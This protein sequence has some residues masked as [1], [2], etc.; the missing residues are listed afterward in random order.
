M[1]KKI[2]DIWIAKHQKCYEGFA[3]HQVMLK[4]DNRVAY[5][6]FGDTS[7]VTGLVPETKP[8][9]EETG[10][11]PTGERGPVEIFGRNSTN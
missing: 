7:E 9:E 3:A 1:C 8:N 4:L 6:Y 10:A 2:I 11:F 5:L